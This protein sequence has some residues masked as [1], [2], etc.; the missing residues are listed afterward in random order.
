MQLHKSPTGTILDSGKLFYL[1]PRRWRCCGD[2]FECQFQWRHCPWSSLCRVLSGR[3]DFSPLPRGSGG[4]R[5]C[6]WRRRG[7]SRAL[8]TGAT[9]PLRPQSPRAEWTPAELVLDSLR[10]SVGRRASFAAWRWPM[11]CC[12]ASI[13][14][15]PLHSCSNI[16]IKLV[17]S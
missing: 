1:V 2:I 15:N 13:T 17:L 6:C 10:Q 5:R 9:G 7:S 4:S 16:E 8:C 11:E 14:S 12:L 3:W